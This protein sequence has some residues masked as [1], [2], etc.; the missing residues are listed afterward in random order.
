MADDDERWPAELESLRAEAR[1]A[2]EGT[3]AMLGVAREAR[4]SLSPAEQ[5]ALSRESLKA[6]ESES[7]AGTDDV[8]GGV[9]CRVLRSASA[10]RGTYLHIHGGGMTLGSPRMSEARNAEIVDRHGVD[11]VSVDYRLAPEHPH[12]AATDDC[13]AVARAL[14]EADRPGTMVVG[15]ESAGA[16]LAA[17]TLLRI[18][19]ELDAIDRV[20]GAN[21]TVGFYDFGGT[22]SHRGVRPTDLPDVLDPALAPGMRAAYL[23]GRSIED[24]RDPAYSPL[25]AP[26]QDLPPALFST[27]LADHL[28]DDSLFMHAR[29]RA[30]GNRAE[31][32]LYPDVGH[33]LGNG[34]DGSSIAMAR[35]ATDRMDDFLTACFA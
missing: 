15:G 4:A 29:W 26:L 3:R 6:M 10:A 14:L 34:M 30:W 23:P 9:P 12:P 35:A 16:Y 20:G 24:T 28:L 2:A 21:L 33:T 32:A 18:R 5:L 22:P 19:D 27:G 13:L 25:Y 8:I 7:A 17:V 1:T 31:L 11:V